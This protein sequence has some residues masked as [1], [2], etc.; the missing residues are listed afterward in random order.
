MHWRDIPFHPTIT[1]LRVFGF[2][3]ALI[4]TGFAG[5][6]YFGADRDIVALTLVGLA[7]AVGMVGLAF[8]AG[9]RPIFVGWMIVVFP[10]NWLVTHLLLACIFYLMVTPLGLFFKLIGRDF[11]GRRFRPDQESYWSSKSSSDDVE[12]YFRPF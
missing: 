6:Q 1:T 11:L 2:G 12:S 7:L 8:P 9:L 4:L 10:M 5:W 3:W